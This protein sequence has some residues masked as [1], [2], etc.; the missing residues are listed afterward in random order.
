[1]TLQTFKTYF[2]EELAAL[3][4]SQE[5]RSILQILCE[6]LLKWNKSQFIMK[7]SDL[8][9][10]QEETTLLEALGELKTSKPVQYI[11][12]KAHFYGHIFK[13]T[14]DALIPR[15]E[16]EE[17]VHLIIQEHKDTIAPR[18]LDI[19]SGSGCIAISLA[20]GLP[21]SQVHAVD[22]STS[23]LQVASDNARSLNAA[24]AFN[25]MDILKTTALDF[26]GIIV[27]NPPYVR[28]L[29]KV[30]IHRNVLDFE[31][32]SALFVE[33]DAA[34]IFYHKILTLAKPHTK[35]LV[36]FEINQYLGLEMLALAQS[37]GFTASLR[38]DL[39]GNDR[40]MKC[41]QV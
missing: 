35:T 2:Q 39:N 31:P 6:D 14:K 28:N 16:T 27:S 18:I 19:G 15:Q 9:T 8:L 24:V 38:K 29:E 22:I 25:Q 4:V 40:M 20:R 12:G 1:M 41:W 33:N 3:Y 5:S 10:A 7:N 17:L 30:A 32:H 26:Y 37:L 34:L 23:A 13:V 36:Y 21:Q 11:T